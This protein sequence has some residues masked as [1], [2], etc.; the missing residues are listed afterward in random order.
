MRPPEDTAFVLI[1]RI[2]FVVLLLQ[3]LWPIRETLAPLRKPW[4]RSEP[5]KDWRKARRKPLPAAAVCESGVCVYM[6][7]CYAEQKSS[8]EQYFTPIT[9]FYMNSRVWIR[10][11]VM[12]IKAVQNCRRITALF[13]NA[14]TSILLSQIMYF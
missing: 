5:K 1:F 11:I 8:I 9:M 4:T 2:M 14:F 13:K 12:H 10:W 7:S 6:I 3:S